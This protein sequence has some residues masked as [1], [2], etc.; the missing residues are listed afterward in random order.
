[1]T[2]SPMMGSRL[3]RSGDTEKGFAGMV[4]RRFEGL[5]RIYARTLSST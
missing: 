3:L 1:L 2:L 4:N 5:Q